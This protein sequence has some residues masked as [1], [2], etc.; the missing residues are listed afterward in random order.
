MSTGRIVLGVVTV[1]VGLAALGIVAANP[2]AHSEVHTQNWS[3]K[4]FFGSFDQAQVK[5]GFQVYKDVCSGCHSMHLIAYRDLQDIGFTE[6]EVKAIAE[7]VQVQDGP[8]D[9]GDMFDRP[10]RPSDHFKSP[11][12]NEQQARASNNGA[13]PPDLSL[14]AKSRAG[15]G[16]LGHD[17]ADYV[18]SLMTG[19]E[20][21]PADV[22]VPEGMHY[23]KAFKGHQIAMPPPLSDGAVTY[24]DGTEATLDQEAKD[25]AVFLTW[26][27]EG[28]LEERHRTGIK[29]VLF[30]VIFTLLAYA[31]KRRVWASVH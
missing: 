11:F 23:N 25:I 3:F 17:G 4:G 14:I 24:A 31:T 16:F 13:L 7:E 10:G 15:A 8:N 20:E 19:Y 22:K 18:Y 9:A 12:A 29:A 26:A 28:N 21:P 5:R 30:L 1:V 6:D 2:V 27:A